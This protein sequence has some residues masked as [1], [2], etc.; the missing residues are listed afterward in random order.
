MAECSLATITAV[1]TQLGNG[2]RKWTKR[3]ALEVLKALDQVVPVSRSQANEF[4][5]YFGLDHAL[6]HAAPLPPSAQA[7]RGQSSETESVSEALQLLSRCFDRF[8]TAGTA[9]KLRDLLADEDEG[10]TEFRHIT[11]PAPSRTVPGALEQKITTYARPKSAAAIKRA[12]KN[13]RAT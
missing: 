13:A 1:E 10:D 4:L 9:A 11:P 2:E 6:F 5:D 8:G 12:T 7:P 3:R